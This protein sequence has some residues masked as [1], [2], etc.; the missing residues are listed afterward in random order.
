MSKLLIDKDGLL[1]FSRDLACIKEIGINGAIVMQQLHYW[2]DINKK[3]YLK[4]DKS[5]LNKYQLG[6]FWTYN[7]L[8]K[9]HTE[10]FPFWSEKTMRRTFDKLIAEGYVIT[11]NFN[12]KGYDQT[13]WYTINYEKLSEKEK[14]IDNLKAIREKEKIEKIQKKNKAKL[15]REIVVSEEKSHVDKM[16]NCD[17]HSCGQND[18]ISW[19]NCPS[20]LDKMTKPIPKTTTKNTTKTS[21][22]SIST[23]KISCN[24]ELIESKTSLIL[25]KNMINKISSWDN[26]RLGKSIDIFLEKEGR[27]FALLEK[28]YKNNR[29]FIEYKEI[30]SSN[31]TSNNSKRFGSS[32]VCCTSEYSKVN[33]KQLAEIESLSC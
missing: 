15:Q 10:N 20:H 18:Q 21:N 19:T 6:R 24:K 28:I 9:W 4:G 1:V 2:I 26:E 31:Y 11:G 16:T 12:E 25:S 7:T 17:K 29:N 23:E 30:T 32:S 13:L 27:Y 14:E 22:I 33:A 3:G 8:E 5:Y